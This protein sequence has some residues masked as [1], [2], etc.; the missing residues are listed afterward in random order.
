MKGAYREQVE[1]ILGTYFPTM[2]PKAEYRE[3]A[4]VVPDLGTSES[5][6]ESLKSSVS[7]Q[8]RQAMAE[9]IWVL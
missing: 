9:E 8:A 7:A 6:M 4:A 1:D 2:Q 5:I 3:Q